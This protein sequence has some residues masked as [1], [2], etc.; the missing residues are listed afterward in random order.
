MNF[1][2][3]TFIKMTYISD[4]LKTNTIWLVWILEGSACISKLVLAPDMK[5]A[6]LADFQW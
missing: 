1:N 2:P 4:L 6:Y 5:N 3:F